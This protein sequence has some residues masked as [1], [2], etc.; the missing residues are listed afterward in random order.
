MSAKQN[1]EYGRAAVEREMKQYKLGKT[2]SADDLARHFKIDKTEDFLA[3]VGFGDITTAQVGGAL[4]LLQRDMR[5]N[6]AAENDTDVVE[7]ESRHS[8]PDRPKH[9]GL[10]VLGVAGLHDH[11]RLLSADSPEPIVGYITRGRGITIHHIDCKQVQAKLVREPERIIEDVDWGSESGTFS[12]PYTIEAYRDTNLVTK[13]ADILKGQNINLLKTKMTH[14][15]S[16]TSAFVLAEVNDLEQANWIKG[17]LEKSI[18]SSRCV[19]ANLDDASRENNTVQAD[20][21]FSNHTLQ[22]QQG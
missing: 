19:A 15:Q 22:M 17:R 7:I 2:V 3:K 10:T 6:L 20:D 9:K 4:A 1:I 18:R 11:R 14:K 8:E 21:L 5:A 13:I 12:V 16:G